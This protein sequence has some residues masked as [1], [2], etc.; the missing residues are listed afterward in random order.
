MFRF[1][2]W[3]R[4]GPF[5]LG[6]SKRGIT[7]VKLGRVSKSRGRSPRVSLPTGI[8]GLSFHLG[9]KRKRRR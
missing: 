5:R 3:I 1:F 9:G 4:L 8:K 2:R 7:T 6:V